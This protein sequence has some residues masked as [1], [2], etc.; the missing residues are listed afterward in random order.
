MSSKIYVEDTS[1][2]GRR[3]EI[4]IKVGRI[5]NLLDELGLEGLVL[6]KQA[7]FS[8]ITAGGKNIVT[9]CTEQG[10][11]SV[12]ITRSGRYVITNTIEACRMRDEEK[13]EE[14]GFEILSQEWYESHD[15]EIIAGIAGSLDKVGT[16]MPIAGAQQI[17]DKINP[18]RYSLTYNEICR[19]QYLGDTLSMS[20]EAFMETIKPGDTEYD[21][22]GRLSAAIWKHNID[23]VL[24]LISSD[25]RAY[26]YRH[27]VP[28]GKKLENH[29]MISVNG[30]YKGLITTVTRFVHFGKPAPEL[31]KQYDDN[32]EIEC[33]MIAATKPGVDEI[34]PYNVGIEA[35]EELGYGDMWKLHHQG[36]GQGYY[37]REYL[38][39]E[40]MHRVTQMNQCYCYNPAISGTKTED[41]FICT[42]NGPLFIT[43]PFTFPKVTKVIDGITFER[44]G[45]FIVD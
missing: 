4:D 37:N 34:V 21:I 9:I 5:H 35:Y 12:L 42:E 40:N 11:A 30:R 25:E 20:L 19:Y 24:F 2:K 10:V 3:E 15:A 38:I 39:S 43:K 14:L 8:W 1:I 28:T 29:L 27:G 6:S 16:D 32:T 41:A 26:K 44:P 7:N 18:L 13:I 36:G 22:A 23:P 33:R 45:M 31:L 17:S